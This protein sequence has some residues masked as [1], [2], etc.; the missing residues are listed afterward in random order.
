MAGPIAA[1]TARAATRASP[2]SAVLLLLN[3][4]YRLCRSI[5]PEPRVHAEV[6]DVYHQIDDHHDH[7]KEQDAALD[8]RIVPGQERVD[9]VPPQAG[10]GEDGLGQDS[11]TQ[12]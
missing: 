12:E 8:R 9:H 6:Q 5:D 4:L 2:A 10:P 11:P 7:G 1:T 3:C